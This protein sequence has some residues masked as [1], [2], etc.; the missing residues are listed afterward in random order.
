MFVYCIVAD[1]RWET[2]RS[3]WRI[4]AVFFSYFWNLVLD[5]MLAEAFPYSKS[6]LK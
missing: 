1:V 3:S 6:D 5:A 4:V 2:A